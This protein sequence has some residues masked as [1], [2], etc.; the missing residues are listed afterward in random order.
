MQLPRGE[1]AADG[2]KERLTA[3]VLQGKALV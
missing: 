3:F 2:M 1:R